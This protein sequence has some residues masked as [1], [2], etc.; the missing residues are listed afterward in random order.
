MNISAYRKIKKKPLRPRT[1]TFL[2][3]DNK[4]VLGLKKRGFGK[5]YLLGIGGKVETGETIEDGARRELAEEI[6]VT[7]LRLRKVGVLNFYFPHVEDESWNQEVHVF[8]ANTWEK[9]PQESEEIKPEWFS[10]ENIPY[11]KM[12][13]DAHYWLPQVLQGQTI[14]GEF[15]FT[16][17]LKVEDYTIK[18]LD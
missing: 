5:G 16:K 10:I 3:K 4:I 8:I 9:E 11:D 6:N 18:P 2:L 7:S 14:E 15:V 17:E 1:I 12:W 13:D